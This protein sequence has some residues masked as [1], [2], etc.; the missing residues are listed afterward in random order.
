MA[1]GVTEAKEPHKLEIRQHNAITTARYEMSAIEMDISF[2][3]LSKLRADDKPGTKYQISVRELQEV[4]GRQ[5][6]H[7]QFL[8][9]TS[10]LRSREYVFEDNKTVLQVGLLASALHRKGEGLIELEISENIRP[11]LIDLKNNFTSF[12]LQAAFMLPSKWAKRIYQIASQWKDIGETKIYSIDDLKVILHLKDPKNKEKEQYSSISLFKKNVLDIA[13][14]QINKFTDLR[15]SYV[16]TKRGRVFTHIRF[17]V[18]KQTIQQL[19]LAFDLPTE[20]VRRQNA[21]TILDD[22][23]IIEEKLVNRILQD[24]NLLNKLFQFN[25]KL[26]T[27]KI[28]ATSN[29]G[30]LFLKIAGL[31]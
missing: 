24:E 2:F 3:L 6:H 25:Y 4:T 14:E 12:Q 28:K 23:N 1:K 13:V 30:G 5:W 21:R 18:N 10:A 17:Y 19:P 29:P 7:G 31:V 15:I 27:D 8:E 22:L 26:K 20:D 11:Y 16:L 9:A